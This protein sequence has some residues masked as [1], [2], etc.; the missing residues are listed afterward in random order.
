MISAAPSTP[1]PGRIAIEVVTDETR[2]GAL[3]DDWHRL[4]DETPEASAFHS[5]TWTSACL[6]ALPS[7]GRPFVLVIRE[8]RRALAILPTALGAHGDL[9]FVG[10]GAVSNYGGPVYRATHV[11]AVID[12]LGAFLTREPRVSLFDL[13][14]LREPSPFLASLRRTAVPGWSMPRPVE[15]ATCPFV[16]LTLGWDAVWARRSGRQRSGLARKARRLGELGTLRFEELDRPDQVRGALPAMADL[17]ARRWAGRHESG[18][19]AGTHRGFHARTAPALAAAGHA[20]VSLLRLDDR[21]VAF[22]YGLVARGVTTSYVLAHDDALGAYSPGLLL[23]V[24]VLEAACRRGDP[25]YD[26]S[27][28]EEIYKDTW[29]TGHRAVV[30]V[31]AWRRGSA[32]A[33]RGRARALGARAWVGARSIDLLRDLRREGIRAVVGGGRR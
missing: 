22:S 7:P 23:L 24:R 29:A 13:G 18:G 25:E 21:I 14:G 10:Q 32:A 6:S 8:G 17:Y 31:L 27:L 12:V 16:D 1:A 3:T 30:R 28:G 20:R 4:L 19:F 2:L 5:L 11:D 15:T 26:F 9:R 33:L